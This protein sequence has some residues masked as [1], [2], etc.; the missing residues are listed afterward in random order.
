MRPRIFNLSLIGILSLVMCSGLPATNG[1]DK[2]TAHSSAQGDLVQLL[3]FVSENFQ[4]PLT[5]ELAQPYPV[6]LRLLGRKESARKALDALIASCPGYAWHEARG[7]AVV[8]NKKLVK[9]RG[10]F[11]NRHLSLFVMPANVAELKLYLPG[12]IE[13]P[14]EAGVLTGIQDNDLAAMT[15]ERQKTMR[16]ITAREVL[17]EVGNENPSFF[18]LVVFPDSDPHSPQQIQYAY[19]YWVMRSNR[20]LIQRPIGLRSMDCPTVD[21]TTFACRPDQSLRPRPHQGSVPARSTGSPIAARR[22]HP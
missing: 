17:V 13:H 20:T 18:S 5:A 4:V 6:G 21:P 12:A 1:F 15:L 16:N 2:V 7:V 10:D 22:G 14:R 11:L 8:Y 3:A 19:T 9:S